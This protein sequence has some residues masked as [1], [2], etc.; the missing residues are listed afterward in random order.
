MNYTIN[1]EVN[2]F[3]NLFT[4][5]LSTIIWSVGYQLEDNCLLLSITYAMYNVDNS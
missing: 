3:S 5:R 2:I 1:K 4:Q